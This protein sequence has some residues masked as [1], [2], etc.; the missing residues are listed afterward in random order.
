M[1]VA[2]NMDKFLVLRNKENK[3]EKKKQRKDIGTYVVPTRHTY[4]VQDIH[5]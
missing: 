2:E 4:V 5:M 1:S 3:K